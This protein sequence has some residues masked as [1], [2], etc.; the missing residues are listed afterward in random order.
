M[1]T[2]LKSKVSSMMNLISSFKSSRSSQ[3]KRVSLELQRTLPSHFPPHLT[4]YAGSFSSDFQ[5]AFF[6]QLL[7]ATFSAWKSVPLSVLF[8]PHLPPALNFSCSTPLTT[9]FRN[10]L[11][12]YSILRTH[13]A[14][15]LFSIRRNSV[16]PLC[17]CLFS[18]RVLEVPPVSSA[19][20][21]VCGFF[22][23]H[24]EPIAEQDHSYY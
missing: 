22:T 24:Q 9:V 19:Q 6:Q 18:S 17:I 14:G 21:L 3:H 10:S 2:A 15:Q 13:M 1:G 7:G 23:A 8:P 5:L 11:C 12:S 20:Q 16:P 4:G